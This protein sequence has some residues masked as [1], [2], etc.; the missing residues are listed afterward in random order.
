M[1][2]LALTYAFDPEG[3]GF[4]YPRCIFFRL[5]GWECPGC[6][7]L[8]ALHALTHGDLPAAWGFNPALPFALLL[9]AGALWV[10]ARGSE[11]LRRAAFSPLAVGALVV[12]VI[13]WTVIRNIY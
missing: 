3:G 9:S 1:A 2:L 13:A 12:A 6:G 10:D 8:R 7:T 4:V 11:S 5:T